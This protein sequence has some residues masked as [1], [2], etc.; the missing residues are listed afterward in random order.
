M[1]SDTPYENEHPQESGS[2]DDLLR[3]LA[4]DA[5]FAVAVLEG[6]AHR[7]ALAN[8]LFC[9]IARGKGEIIG[10]TVAEV[11]PETAHLLVPLLDGVYRSGEAYRAEDMSMPMLRDGNI[12]TTYFTFSWTPLRDESG[13]V[14]GIYVLA[15]ETTAQVLARAE[16]ERLLAQMM[17]VYESMDE[18]LVVMDPQGNLLT[19]N[20]AAQNLLKLDAVSG[21]HWTAF[22]EKW[23]VCTPDGHP[24]PPE[25]WPAARTLR[26]ENLSGLELRLCHRQSERTIWAVFGGA[27]VRS[28]PVR[29]A[30][31]RAADGDII[32]AVITL[33]DITE[34]V[35]AER[36][37]RDAEGHLRDVMANMQDAVYRTNLKTG[38]HEYLS[39]AVTILTGLTP[40]EY[41]QMSIQEARARFHPDDLPDHIRALRSTGPPNGQRIQTVEYRF[42][43]KDGRYRWLSNHCTVWYDAEGHPD[44]VMGTLRDVT[45]RVEAE[46]AL[47][48]SE[49]RF[50]KAFRANPNALVLSRIEDGTI[51]DVN[52]AFLDLF[53]QTR[54]E[55]I[56]KTS[57]A[58]NMF[59][60]PEERDRMID[61]MRRDGRL[62]DYQIRVRRKSGEERT[63]NL[64]SE[65]LRTGQEPF[66]LTIMQDITER[67]QIEREREEL[68][69]RLD[70][71]RARLQTVLDALPVGVW[72]VDA[73]GRVLHYNH[74]AEEIWTRPPAYSESADAYGKDYKAWWPDTGERVQSHEWGMARALAHGE[75]VSAE[76]V[77][78]EA[79][80]GQRKS[81]LNYAMPI[82]APDGLS[83]GGVTVQVDITELKHAQ[84]ALRE[85]EQRF[86]ALMTATSEV[87]YRMSPDWR[88]MRQLHSRGFL[89]D[90]EEP[91]RDWL[92]EY[93]HP[94]D[95]PQV[96]AVIEEAIREK[97]VFHFE[98]R[99]R[100]VDGTLGWTF[101]RAVP[102]LDHEGE[103]VEWFGVASDI[104]ERKQAEEAI[105]ESEAR[106]RELADAMPQLVWMARPDGTVD[107]YNRRYQEF[108]GI[109]P[110]GDQWEWAPVLHPDDV[111]PTV[112]AW[113]HAV[114]T[115]TVY[116]I[117][118]RVRMADG[119]Y[120]WHLSRGTPVRDDQG[121]VIRWYGTAT[122][123]HATKQAEEAIRESE[124]RF[125]DLAE[126]M[127][128]LIWIADPDGTVTYY[129]RRYQEFTGITLE[130]DDWKWAPALHPDDVERTV[131]A[132]QRAVETGDLYEIEQR[133]QRADG[134][135]HWY[136]S[137]GTP[138]RNAQGR[139]IQWYGTSTDI[140]DLKRAEE[141]L[142]ELNET[143][144]QRVQERT[145]ELE[146][147]AADLRRAEE[148]FRIALA[149]SPVIVATLDREQR[150]TWIYN[151]HPLFRPEEVLGKRDDELSPPADIHEFTDF[152][153]SVLDSGVGARKEVSVT[154]AGGTHYYD[155]TAEPLRDAHGE[156]IG[157]TTSA[158]DVTEIRRAEMELRHLNE[159]LEQRTD[160]LRA[161]A[162][163]L[164]RAEERERHRVARVLHDHLQQ[165]LVAAQIQVNIGRRIVPA[166]AA[167]PLERAGEFID[168]S[169]QASRDLTAQLSPPI[170]YDAGLPAALGW[171]SRWM[172]DRHGLNIQQQVDEDVDVPDESLR[173]FMFQS[174]RE[175]L[176]NVVKHAGTDRAVLSWSR[177]GDDLCLAVED[178]GAGFV[179]GGQQTD[180]G[181]FGLFSIRE[182]LT[183]LGGQIEIDS[184]PGRGARVSLRVPAHTGGADAGTPAGV[185]H[186]QGDEQAAVAG[187]GQI[188][189]LVA[190]DHAIMRQGLVTMLR[191]E[192]DIEVVGEASDGLEAVEFARRRH[193]DVVLM[194]V[195][196]PVL[197]G[198]E[199]T[200]QIRRDLPDTQ[201][202]GLS[203]FAE[204]EMAARMSSVGAAAYL[205]KSGDLNELINTVRR[206]SRAHRNGA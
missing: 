64:S 68:I 27:P 111:E 167:G 178:I 91:N 93:I 161:L 18:G 4:D 56:G 176:F 32:A 103:I 158:T 170:L 16:R 196:M 200:A 47:R 43:H 84:D 148:R 74:G 102:L 112:Y 3:R 14:R 140:D 92:Q 57:R 181:S 13:H 96:L 37:L 154:L 165:I 137:R 175:L 194:D 147:V 83:L 163:E 7:F 63:A 8:D 119:S 100:R 65:V 69:H 52:G 115:G 169:I 38:Q 197:D 125:R 75:V 31:G 94:D 58:L 49:E 106:F 9:A 152:K 23:D 186:V 143:L 44:V 19:I 192:P 71:E 139:I 41:A 82:Q 121:H 156:V 174:A 76:E 162:T 136:L 24:L 201:V 149:N 88:E 157:L 12:E 129:N 28:A 6:P 172:Q 199:A 198:V 36:A 195:R 107:Y 135:Y 179:D 21:Q 122:D 124:A 53:Q 40:D 138:I 79:L 50:A 97:K 39:P 188:R 153:Q 114:E 118:H 184:A 144:D 185:D 109:S 10:R 46:Q 166:S 189:V 126:S 5:P 67:K 98:H 182:R 108:G 55:V 17:G 141:A 150:Y 155:M 193:P 35:K 160:Q 117:E 134:T 78:I 183:H 120:R 113:Q 11:W 190:D 145:A 48:Q 128:Q 2:F 116:E 70:A 191:Q 101:S 151:P 72:I 26:G 51:L 85:S 99:V 110:D 202:V 60:H 95:Q 30:P 89:A 66:L 142:R 177:Q 15:Q 180:K 187:W 203:M 77:E 87:L 130:G 173:A 204:P 171:L 159:Q 131:R 80:D 22:T 132:W 81:I 33:H 205:T 146:A 86:R 59:A 206:V 29:D 20:P 104:T 1:G 105:R 34:R 90:T 168:E 62:F 42:L 127:P 133:V 123:I 45:D 61:L 73:E 54:E 164:T 25:D